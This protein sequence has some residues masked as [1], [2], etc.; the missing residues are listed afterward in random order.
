MCTCVHSSRVRMSEPE[1]LK[2][3][4]DTEGLIDKTITFSRSHSQTGGGAGTGADS[5]PGLFLPWWLCTVRSSFC[6]PAY[7]HNM[8]RRGASPF[9]G[10][11][12]DGG[13][14]HDNS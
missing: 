6:L 10:G 8:L 11:E 3:I 4:E 7:F 5:E 14:D 1:R 13:G 12:G 2:E 9:S